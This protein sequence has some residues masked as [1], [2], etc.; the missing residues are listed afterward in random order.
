MSV[1]HNHYLSSPKDQ[2]SSKSNFTGMKDGSLEVR[3]FTSP[4]MHFARSDA[5]IVPKE[6]RNQ[7]S[8]SQSIYKNEL[9]NKPDVFERINNLDESDDCN[10]TNSVIIDNGGRNL[11]NMMQM[12]TEQSA[13][14]GSSAACVTDVDHKP[15]KIPR[16]YPIG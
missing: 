10:Q 8:L 16:D 7:M 2:S 13:R 6:N 12:Y 14:G 11:V 5:L 3:D 4:Q 9:I 15:F 1:E